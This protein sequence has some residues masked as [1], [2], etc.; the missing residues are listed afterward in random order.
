MTIKLPFQ[1][2]SRTLKAALLS[3]V[4]L[5]SVQSSRAQE[6][7][8]RF[9]QRTMILSEGFREIN[10][11]T[12]LNFALN[13][14]RLDTSKQVEIGT[15][16]LTLSAALGKLLA[17]SGHTYELYD[18]HIL[19]IPIQEQKENTPTPVTAS[20]SDNYN[21]YDYNI[22]QP[23]TIEPIQPIRSE[24]STAAEVIE[25][26]PQEYRPAEKIGERTFAAPKDKV[27]KYLNR[28]D[29]RRSAG[30]KVG[31]KTNLLY[32]GTT[33]PNL[34]VELALGA[35]TTLDIQG[36]YNPWKFGDPEKNKK[37]QHWLVMPE[38]RMWVHEKFD[39][40]FFGVHGFFSSYNAGNVDLPLGI[41]SDL[42]DERREGYGVGVGISYG[43]QWY[44]GN[45]W[46]LEATF[47]FGYSY[48]NY[49]RYECE[50]CGKFL[51]HTHKHY[52]GPT[53]IGLSFIYLFK[54]KR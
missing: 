23:K 35:K 18:K 37:I 43:Y 4:L 39:G 5:F 42:K 20:A 17:G 9:P 49:D 15:G 24:S 26:T 52:F 48:M 6:P 7:V 14:S 30:P 34:A 41:F 47:G 16:Q 51:E 33:T 28:A 11:Q 10:R 8:I 22:P 21:H 2:T 38:V 32:W 1:A 44:L 46:N 29:N 45:H 25:V 31:I 36:S 19:I 54:S 12:G 13:L 3:F 50:P 40:H 27:F 53:K